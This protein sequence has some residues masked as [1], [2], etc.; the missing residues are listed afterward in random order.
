MIDSNTQTQYVNNKEYNR[1]AWLDVLKLIGVLLVYIGHLGENAGKLFFFVWSFHVPLLFFCSGYVHND[2]DSFLHFCRKKIA[3]VLAPYYFFI[4]LCLAKQVF[5]ETTTVSELGWF[6]INSL[7]GTKELQYAQP[8]WFLPALF[9]MSLI[10]KGIHSIIPNPIARLC[11]AV[12]LSAAAN[13]FL[14]NYDWLPFCI[15]YS[16]AFLVYYEFGFFLNRISEKMLPVFKY[17]ALL[18][19]VYAGVYYVHKGPFVVSSNSLANYF[20]GLFNT[21]ALVIAFVF[22]AK[23]LSGSRSLA[24][25]GQET[26][27][28]LGNEILV[29]TVFSYIFLML[30]LNNGIYGEMEAVIF[31]IVL[32]VFVYKVLIPIEKPIIDRFVSA[33]YKMFAF[34]DNGHRKR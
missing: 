25:M 18:F 22:L 3:R 15:N 32:I 31:C 14:L 23:L 30:G 29:K 5:I 26:L 6:L 16:L 21:L 9:S 33:A 19:L 24:E 10:T 2:M 12:V 17:S 1:I 7:F 4:L 28:M 34:L 8:L 20:I 27:Y 13:L 11:V